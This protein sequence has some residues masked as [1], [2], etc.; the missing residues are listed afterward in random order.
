[1][2]DDKKND[3]TRREELGWV[4]WRG[5]PKDKNTVTILLLTRFVPASEEKEDTKERSIQSQEGST[6]LIFER[7][8]KDNGLT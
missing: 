1:M 6:K 4:A 5:V 8:E 2:T 7:R 3:R